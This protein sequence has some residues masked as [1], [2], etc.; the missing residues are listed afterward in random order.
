MR[1]IVD[2]LLDTPIFEMALERK[3]YIEYLEGDI[4]YQLLENWCLVKYAK[5][6]NNVNLNHWTKELVAHIQKLNRINIKKLSKEKEL[7]AL[8]YVFVD[9]FELNK[10]EN[11]VDFVSRKFDDENIEDPEIIDYIAENFM[12]NLDE[13]LKVCVFAK[14]YQEI[15][16][17]VE[18][19]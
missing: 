15:K 6:T 13:F 4:K 11:V 12:D 2:Y 10:K 7:K 14:N 9:E 18:N 19:I 17:Y 16:T 5:L 3:R 8:K 1:N